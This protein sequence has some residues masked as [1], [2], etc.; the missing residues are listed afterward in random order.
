MASTEDGA[1]YTGSSLSQFENEPDTITQLPEVASTL[2]GFLDCLFP[3]VY[4]CGCTVSKV[5][6][7]TILLVH[8]KMAVDDREQFACLDEVGFLIFNS[9]SL[10]F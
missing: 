8:F 5:P 4:Q 7:N 9:S 3:N 2:A 1:M 10:F 6:E